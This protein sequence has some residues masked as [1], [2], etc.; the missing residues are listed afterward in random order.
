MIFMYWDRMNY[1]NV[2]TGLSNRY[3]VAPPALRTVLQAGT[4]NRRHG[5]GDPATISPFLRFHGRQGGRVL[6]P[7]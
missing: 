1:S 6:R 3:H 2:F 5:D 4:Q 7:A